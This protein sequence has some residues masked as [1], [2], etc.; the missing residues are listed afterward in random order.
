MAPPPDKSRGF[1]RF[2]KRWKNELSAWQVKY[3]YSFTLPHIR[4]IFYSWL[5]KLNLNARDDC[6]L[7]LPTSYFQSRPKN[8]EIWLV[9]LMLYPPLYLLVIYYCLLWKIYL[10]FVHNLWYITYLLINI[11]NWI[12]LLSHH[13]Q[14]NQNIY[15]KRWQNYLHYYEHIC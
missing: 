2:L 7:A 13:R 4:Q 6:P 14:F 11:I 8:N 1:F 3:P 15:A 10:I 9:I 12:V 5:K